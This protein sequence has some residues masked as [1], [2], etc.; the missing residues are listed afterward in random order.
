MSSSFKSFNKNI[1]KS[2]VIG[3]AVAC[4]G[5]GASIPY[6]FKTDAIKVQ[7]QQLLKIE[8]IENDLKGCMQQK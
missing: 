4:V 2:L 1:S 8:K 6:M 3:G 5:I 7:E